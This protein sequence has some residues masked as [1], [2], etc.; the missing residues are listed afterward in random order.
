MKG[1]SVACFE[2]HFSDG[3]WFTFR[4]INDQK[5]FVSF[6]LF[7]LTH[8]EAFISL[9]YCDDQRSLE[10]LVA[11]VVGEAQLIEAGVGRRQAVG[12]CRRSSDLELWIQ[13]LRSERDKKVKIN[14]LSIHSISDWRLCP[15]EWTNLRTWNPPCGNCEQPV[16]NCNNR[17]ISV[18][19]KL[20]TAA[21]NQSVD[22]VANQLIN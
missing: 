1:F 15:I 11:F 9:A 4:S 8:S 18:W 19:E 7:N 14:E 21:Q 13:F 5:L 22:K 3:V 20:L 2:F 12:E 17:A 10:L 16:V 6:Y